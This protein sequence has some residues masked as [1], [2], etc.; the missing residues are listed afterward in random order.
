[1][2]RILAA[3]ASLCLFSIV[4]ATGGELGTREEAVAM[5]QRVKA[6]F[7]KLGPTAT[8]K[9]I[10]DRANGF[11][12]RDLYAFVYDIKGN[13][14]AH[15]GN[16]QLIGRNRMDLRDQNGKYV[17]SALVATALSKGKGWVDYSLPN[18]VTV[19]DMSSYVEVLDNKYIVGVPVLRWD[20]SL[21]QAFDTHRK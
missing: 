12:D 17:V 7:R 1:M 14:I 4:P 6:S 16:A 18:T 10:T 11:H 8:F 5:A 9:A 19:E 20:M 15:G 21:V 2:W 13:V 3:V